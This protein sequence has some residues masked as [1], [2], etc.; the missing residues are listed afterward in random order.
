MAQIIKKKK[1]DSPSYKDINEILKKFDTNKDVKLSK[2]RFEVL[3]KKL[4]RELMI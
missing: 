2:K 1:I 4:I 3:V